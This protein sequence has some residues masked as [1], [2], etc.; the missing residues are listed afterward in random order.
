MGLP[1]D[2]SLT[3]SVLKL[4]FVMLLTLD[5]KVCNCYRRHSLVNMNY[6][7]IFFWDVFR[8]S[9]LDIFKV[10]ELTCEEHQKELVTSPSLE[11]IIHYDLWAREYAARFQSSSRMAPIPA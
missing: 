3:A 7:L 11:E 5:C 9:Y 1:W 8:I 4:P 6:L 10:V 2:M